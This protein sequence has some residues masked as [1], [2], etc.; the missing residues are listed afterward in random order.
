[1]RQIGYEVTTLN[2]REITLTQL[3]KYD[4]VVLGI[5]A[6]NVVPELAYKNKIL[7]EYVKEGGNVLVQ[8]NT[9]HALVTEEISPLPLKLSRIRVT[10]EDSKVNFINPTHSALNYPNKITEKDFEGWIQERGLYFPNEWDSTFESLFSMAD[11]GEEQVEGS[12]LILPYGKGNYVY[13]G[14][15]FFRELPAGVPGAYRLIANL[16]SLKN[17]E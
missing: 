3:K 12:V 7:F 16:L 4:A 9:N 8:Y 13:T 11:T 6:F 1:M 17:K 5:R 15:S 10:E 14:L 2:P